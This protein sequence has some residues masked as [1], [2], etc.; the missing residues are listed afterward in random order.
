MS[1][2]QATLAR[3]EAEAAKMAALKKDIAA[4]RSGK[5]PPAKKARKAGPGERDLYC[6]HHDPIHLS[7]VH[8]SV[9]DLLTV[10]ASHLCSYSQSFYGHSGEPL[11]AYQA[12]DGRRPDL[13]LRPHVCAVMRAVLLHPGSVAA[14]FGQELLDMSQPWVTLSTCTPCSKGPKV[15]S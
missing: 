1:A 4:S 15:T 5:P 2:L 11:H 7:V 3:F 9:A 14:D 6:I 12:T 8:C 13:A 10:D